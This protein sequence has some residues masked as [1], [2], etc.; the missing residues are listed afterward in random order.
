[1]RKP[2]VWP[3]FGKTLVEHCR[4][5]T[6]PSITE[7]D[8]VD[9]WELV[10]GKHLFVGGAT[11]RIA[12]RELSLAGAAGSMAAWKRFVGKA[13]ATGVMFRM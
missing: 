5:G 7:E 13:R 8:R 2:E 10:Y 4:S 3:G 9:Q 12:D 6:I 11:H 1:M